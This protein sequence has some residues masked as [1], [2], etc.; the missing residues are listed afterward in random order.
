MNR[1]GRVVLGLA[2]VPLLGGCVA[3]GY[4]GSA[5]MYSGYG[6]VHSSNVS[7]GINVPVYPSLV[8]IPGYPV[9][10][11]P[12][13]ATN[14]FFYDG[15]YWVFWD[16]GWYQST[17]YNGPW[18][19]V[20]P[21][22]VPLFI[23]RVPVRYYR[24]PPAYFRGW[25]QD[26]PPRWGEHWGPQWEQHRH[27]WDQWNRS[28]AP[29]PAPLPHYQ[30]EYSGSK[31]PRLEQQPVLRAERYRYQPQDPA[32]RQLYQER[33]RE[34]IRTQP[35]PPA[36]RGYVPAPQQQRIQPMPQER[37]QRQMEYQRSYP[38]AP[39]MQQQPQPQQMQPRYQPQQMQQ[40]YQP[41]P[42][43]QQLQPQPQQQQMQQRYQSQPQPQ[44]IQ[45]R[46]D[47]S[48]RGQQPGAGQRGGAPQGQGA[49][50]RDNRQQGQGGRNN[51]RDERQRQDRYP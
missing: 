10:Y 1:L 51:D 9:Y 27:G 49:A 44:Q 6:V 28:A 14:Y 29:A 18:V 16:D 32:G 3:A 2:T 20:S 40:R 50:Q 31:Y 35:Q 15:V 37:N 24:Y 34:Q 47:S 46:Q 5:P 7:I 21:D 43:L 8:R 36:Q 41:Q 23:L 4:P 45:P 22:M 48:G 30:R 25:H 19:Y 42:Q 39:M 17:W 13:V 12:G 11:A 26:A 38:S 33:E